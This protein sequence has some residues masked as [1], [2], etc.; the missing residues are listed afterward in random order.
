LARPAEAAPLNVIRSLA[1]FSQVIDEALELQVDDAYFRHLRQR[2]A[3]I[4]PQI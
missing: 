3:R 2:L 4:L 1:Y